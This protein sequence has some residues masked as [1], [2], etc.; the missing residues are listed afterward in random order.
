MSEYATGGPL[1]WSEQLLVR[2]DPYCSYR[3]PARAIRDYDP[4]FLA[5]PNAQEPTGDS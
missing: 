5:W 4:G 2:I 1:P 3:L